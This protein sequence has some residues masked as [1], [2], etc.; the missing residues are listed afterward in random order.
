[1]TVREALALINETLDEVLTEQEG[2]FD[3]DSRLGSCLGLNSMGLTWGSMVLLK[4]YQRQRTLVFRHV[5]AGI[6]ESKSGKAR[7][8]KPSEL[9]AD[10][11]PTVDERLTVWE[12]VHHLIRVLEAGGETVLLQS[13][14]QSL[15]ARQIL[16]GN[17]HIVFTY[18]VSERKDF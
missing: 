18:H 11:D 3:A 16:Q 13:L 15:E 6:L 1:M 4:H 17:L 12:I 8:L 10:W 7:I 2:D 9:P 5:E 14:W